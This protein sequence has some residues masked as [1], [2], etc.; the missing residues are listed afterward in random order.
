[1]GKKVLSVQCC[2]INLIKCLETSTVYIFR[3]PMRGVYDIKRDTLIHPVYRIYS[4][5]QRIV[6]IGEVGL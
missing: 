4:A 1:M 5:S 3:S 6:G 2:R